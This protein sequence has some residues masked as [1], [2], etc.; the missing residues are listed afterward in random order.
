M[1]A[2][3]NQEVTVRRPEAKRMPSRST[4]RRARLRGSSHWAKEAKT[5]D[6]QVGRCEDDMAGSLA[7]GFGVVTVILRRGPAF[8]H[9]MPSCLVCEVFALAYGLIYNFVESAGVVLRPLVEEHDEDIG[10]RLSFKAINPKFLLKY[11]E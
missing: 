10:G 2:A 5:L 3:R 8:V 4:G 7:R 11:D 1:P 9:L 6:N